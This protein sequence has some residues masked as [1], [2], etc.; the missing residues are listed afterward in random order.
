MHESCQLSATWCRI[1]RCSVRGM[2]LTDH[3]IGLNNCSGT[4]RRVISLLGIAKCLYSLY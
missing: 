3:F 2:T 4:D 1:N